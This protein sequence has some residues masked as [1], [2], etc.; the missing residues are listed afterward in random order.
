MRGQIKQDMAVVGEKCLWTRMLFNH[1]SILVR[2]NNRVNIFTNNNSLFVSI[3]VLDH[4][5]TCADQLE[6]KNKKVENMACRL[7]SG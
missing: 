1:E 2:I 6:I 7:L 5:T 4:Y 3:I